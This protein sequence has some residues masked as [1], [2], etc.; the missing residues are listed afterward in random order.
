AIAPRR[1]IALPS[2][3]P[4]TWRC[5]ST[6]GAICAHA[7]FRR[8]PRM[9]PAAGTT[10]LRCPRRSAAWRRNPGRCRCS[11][12]T[13]T[14]KPMPLWRVLVLVCLAM[15]AGVGLGYV[16]WGREARESREALTR[17]LETRPRAVVDP[18]PWLARGIVRIILADQGV[19]F[20]THEAIQGLM[21]GA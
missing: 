7:G 12:S 17:A 20:V 19:V 5:W 9:R 11:A 3:H 21:P 2:H 15:L 14:E 16:R 18:G 13:S 6:A 8:T 10:W 1:A 4:F